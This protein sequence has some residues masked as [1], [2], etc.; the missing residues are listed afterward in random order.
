M[1]RVLMGALAMGILL[2]GGAPA[3]EFLDIAPQVNVIV[4]GSRSF[5]G[6]GVADIDAERTKALKLKEERGVEITR[7]ESDSPAAKAGLK[8]GDVVLEYNGQRIE[9]TEQFVRMVRETPAGRQ[10]KLLI[11][12][13]GSTQTVTAAIAE[14]KG[15]P[16]FGGEPFDAERLRVQSE[17]LKVQGEKIKEQAEKMQQQFQ[18]D[19]FRRQLRS[20]P[21]VPQPNMSWRSGSLGILAESLDD[22]LAEYFGVKEGVLVRSVNK[23]SAA[24]KAGLKAGDVILKVDDTKVTTPRGITTAIRNL[25]DKRTFPV[26]V[27]RNHKEMT[28]SVTIDA[29]RSERAPR[30]PAR[31]VGADAQL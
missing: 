17:K 3:Q 24:E 30:F 15:G 14:R 4:A 25:K 19:E 1:R 28:L 5:L 10:A 6:V 2:A 18:S 29:D 26:I 11:S 12:R 22:Q 7:V 31:M 9:G 23:S 13:D 27:S 8:A 20:I 16:F 21:D